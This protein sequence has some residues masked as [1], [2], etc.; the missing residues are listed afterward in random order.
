LLSVDEQWAVDIVMGSIAALPSLTDFQLDFRGAYNSTLPLHLLSDLRRITVF[1]D[2]DKYNLIPLAKTIAHSPELS[3]L[4]LMDHCFGT[5]PSLNDL[6]G[7][8]VTETRLPL[9]HLSLTYWTVH[10]DEVIL[11]HFKSLTSFSFQ[12]FQN[13]DSGS[14]NIWKV[15]LVEGIRL[16]ELST[17]AVS[18]ELVE[19]IASSSGLCSLHLS[20][21][22]TQRTDATAEMFFCHP[23]P[24]HHHTLRSLN[25]SVEYESNSS[26]C[27]SKA[28]ASFIFGCQELDDLSVTLRSDCLEHSVVS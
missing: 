11:Q 12:S 17:N 20:I 28:N 13:L 16:T 4:D 21:P 2:F 7:H 5:T 27:F 25:L 22:G 18:D 14:K 8:E 9:K 1:G 15:F 19:F 10:L 24:L 3:H 23:L 26:W 6:F